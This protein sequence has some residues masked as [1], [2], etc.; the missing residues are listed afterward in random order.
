MYKV[1]TNTQKL[2]I[3]KVMPK[4]FSY[5]WSRDLIIHVNLG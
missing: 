5:R 2:Y 1:M 3:P 4:N